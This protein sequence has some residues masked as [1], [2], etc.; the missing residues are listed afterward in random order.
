VRYFLGLHPCQRGAHE[1]NN[2]G[3]LAAYRS[4][5]QA[6]EAATACTERLREYL[7]RMPF[8]SLERSGH[9]QLARHASRVPPPTRP[10]A[11]ADR[12]TDVEAARP[13]PPQVTFC[14]LQ[15]EAGLWADY[16]PGG[17]LRRCTPL[18]YHAKFC[19]MLAMFLTGLAGRTGGGRAAGAA[20]VAL[21]RPVCSRRGDAVLREELQLRCTGMPPPCTP[22]SVGAPVPWAWL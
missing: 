5:G 20:V 11:L 17:G 18:T 15:D 6:S 10:M 1:L 13:L 22:S 3:L 2:L 12:P 16:P 14:R 7:M 21:A 4:V 9:E 8:A 19:A